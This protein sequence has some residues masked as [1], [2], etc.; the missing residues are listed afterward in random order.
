MTRGAAVVL[1]VALSGLGAGVLGAVPLAAQERM[2]AYEH[3]HRAFPEFVDV[4]FTQHA[5][6]ERKVHPRFDAIVAEAGKQYSESVEL[7]WQFNRWFGA[8]IAAAA[9]QTDP[10]VGDGVAGFGDMEVAPMIT[11]VQD[12]E[13][14]LIVTARSGFVLPTGDESEGLGVDGW[15]WRPRFLL[16][17]GFGAERR[18][19]LQVEFGYDLSFMEEGDDEKALAFNV[20]YSHWTH[21]NWIPVME[22]T[23]VQGVG[24]HDDEGAVPV[25]KALMRR[26]DRRL[27]LSHGEALIESDDR[28]LSSA[29]GFRYA[30]EN[31]QQWGGGVQFPLFGD[32]ESYDWR[33]VFGGIFHLR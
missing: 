3:A 22:I 31:G 17:K 21:S 10:E 11:F 16:W 24:G 25:D 19:A 8:E 5:Y 20:G 2:E 27:G 9:I 28:R 33:L 7:V 29:V 23:A 13:R 32:T 15:S 6:L 4:F 12:P 18:G 30:F 14:L 1:L 26:G